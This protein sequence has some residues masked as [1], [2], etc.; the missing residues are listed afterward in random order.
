MSTSIPL[1]D[2]K[3]QHA[4]VAAEVASGF[5]RVMSETAFIQGKDVA[6]FE[7]AFAAFSGVKHCIGV[8]N[9]T[10][11]LELALRA[12]GIGPGDEVLVP[13]NTFIAT[14][15]AVVRAG[16][17]P[18]L[19]DCDPDYL[20]TAR[21]RFARGR[22]R[23]A[24]QLLVGSL[25]EVPM[26]QKVDV[27]WCAQSMYSLSNPDAALAQMH[28]I[29]RPGGLAV[30]LENDTLHQLLLPWPAR[31]A[32]IAPRHASAMAPSSAPSRRS[33]RRSVSS[34]PNRQF[35]TWPSAVRRVRSQAPQNGCE[36]LAM[37]PTRTGRP[38]TVECPAT[39]QVSAG[40]AP[41]S[42]GSGSSLNSARSWA[43]ISSP[44]T[45]SSRRHACWASSGIC[46]MIRS[47]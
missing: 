19:V 37:T 27:V 21:E 24:T 23:C 33:A 45:I 26:R 10:D 31:L 5:E 35:R 2:L 17:M 42:C 40:A 8:A 6:Q 7:Q 9:G 13:A 16:A 34:W 38:S 14:A 12:N 3:A 39:T 25:S 4:Q 32:H 36:T 11:A 46:S 29:L 22:T 1:V 18:R 43:R 44:G 30:V 28:E 47:W 20:T 15:L 41:R